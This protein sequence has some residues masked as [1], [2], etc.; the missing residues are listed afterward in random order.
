MLCCF[1][2]KNRR[3]ISVS[4]GKCCPPPK[5]KKRAARCKASSLLRHCIYFQFKLPAITSVNAARQLWLRCIQSNGTYI[6]NLMVWS[7]TDI[8]ARKPFVKLKLW[9]RQYTSVVCQ[10]AQ[11]QGLIMWWSK[12]LSVASVMP[13]L[14]TR[15]Q[16]SWMKRAII[17][18][19][20][21]KTFQSLW[22]Y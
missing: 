8:F 5:K 9:T 7:T 2:S 21:L 20:S 13:R 15:L 12:S 16:T 11:N 3:K 17:E 6:A 10:R 22:N 14:A 4:F 1:K 19:L 18:F